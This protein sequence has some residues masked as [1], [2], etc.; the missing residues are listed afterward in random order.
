MPGEVA[1]ISRELRPSV[2]ELC[3]FSADLS[4]LPVTHS[5]VKGTQCLCFNSMSV[6]TLSFHYY[7]NANLA[8][9]RQIS[10]L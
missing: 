2:K 1:I 3:G 5:L 4:I 10:F 6:R 8:V 7:K 9:S